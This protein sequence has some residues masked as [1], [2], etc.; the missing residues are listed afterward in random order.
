[1]M[2]IKA[3][4]VTKMA[5]DVTQMQFRGRVF[6]GRGIETVDVRVDDRG[7]V[8]AWDDVA[9]HYT[10]CHA[11]SQRNLRAIRRAAK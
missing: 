11:L 5:S 6:A 1:M 3:G 10:R 7:D 8:T 2:T 4:S 9:E